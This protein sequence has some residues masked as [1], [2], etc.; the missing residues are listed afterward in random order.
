MKQEHEIIIIG[1]AGIG[2]TTV[3]YFQE[4]KAKVV[5][6]NDFVQAITL[7]PLLEF[8]IKEPNPFTHKS[9]YHK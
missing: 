4:E 7:E 6:I 5:L 3:T 8:E 2:K 9:K 1:C